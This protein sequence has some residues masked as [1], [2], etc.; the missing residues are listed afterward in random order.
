MRRLPSA[1]ILLSVLAATVVIAQQPPVFTPNGA[2]P[3]N[4]FARYYQTGGAVSAGL[5]GATATFTL[6]YQ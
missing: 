2:L 1:I 4:Y 3:V 6:S 5:L